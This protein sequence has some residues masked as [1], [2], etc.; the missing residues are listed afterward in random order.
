MSDS[1]KI[2]GEF[3][4]VRANIDTDNLQKYL[5]ANVPRI[6]VPITVKQFKVSV[7]QRS[8]F[9]SG[10]NGSYPQFGQVR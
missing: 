4:E 7:P 6:H 1:Q 5:K 2:G 3:G 8:V 10:A 9:A